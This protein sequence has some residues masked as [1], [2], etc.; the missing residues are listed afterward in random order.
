VVITVA[1][2]QKLGRR[3]QEAHR[4]WLFRAGFRRWAR[5]QAPRA[6]SRHNE[7]HYTFYA[8]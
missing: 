4:R 2:K 3:H 8:A 6:I 5:R 7:W 1:C